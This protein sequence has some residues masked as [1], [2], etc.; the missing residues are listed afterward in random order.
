MVLFFPEGSGITTF[1][2][3]LQIAAINQEERQANDLLRSELQKPAAELRKEMLRYLRSITMAKGQTPSFVE[4]FRECIA[5][6]FLIKREEQRNFFDK[7]YF[8]RNKRVETLVDPLTIIEKEWKRCRNLA[9]TLN[10]KFPATNTLPDAEDLPKLVGSSSTSD[11]VLVEAEAEVDVA[12]E[13]EVDVE[14]EVN[15]NV[16]IEIPTAEGI[17][18]PKPLNW[19]CSDNYYRSY[20]F[21]SIS[22]AKDKL[23]LPLH[24]SSSLMMTEN[25]F[26]QYTTT[27]YPNVRAPFDDRMKEVQYVAIA[28]YKNEY[29]FNVTTTTSHKYIAM[30]HHDMYGA[31]RKGKL[32]EVSNEIL[33]LCSGSFRTQGKVI[34]YD[35]RTHKFLI[36]GVTHESLPEDFYEHIAQMRFFSGQSEQVNWSN[37]DIQGL[38][39]WLAPL[40][41]RQIDELCS[42]MKV[43]VLKYKG[44]ESQ[45][46]DT[47]WLGQVLNRTK[48]FKE[49]NSSTL[50]K[51][52]ANVQ[53]L[54]ALILD[55]NSIVE[56]QARCN[57]LNSTPQWLIE[58]L[59]NRIK[60][61]EIL[62]V[63]NKIK[64]EEIDEVYWSFDEKLLLSKYLATA[65][66][67]MIDKLILKINREFS[68]LS[69]VL[70]REIALDLTT[71]DTKA[72]GTSRVGGGADAGGGGGGGAAPERTSL[73]RFAFSLT[74]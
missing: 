64:R 6:G 12:V 62:R 15:L 34:F 59:N 7:E 63:L 23:G 41:P 21:N 14:A 8:E 44:D 69:Q 37:N 74:T 73:R 31:S 68:W 30:D 16:G 53:K 40:N 2:E 24:F 4:F 67:S 1:E 22:D 61:L 60:E 45:S 9:D 49:L 13:A 39:N 48:A 46:F 10:L 33:K 38:L 58:K 51:D 35:T 66:K 71:A 70:S 47:S 50:S 32:N 17:N 65:D 57:S 72:S 19:R 36:D 25:F 3:F 26:P 54:V 27:S 11:G 42:F 18:Y 43:S 52:D 5:N 55:T 28:T 29:R 20:Q 56:L